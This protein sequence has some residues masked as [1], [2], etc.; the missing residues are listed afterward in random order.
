[1]FPLNCQSQMNLRKIRKF[2]ENKNRTKRYQKSSI[3]YMQELLNND[4]RRRKS[5]MKEPD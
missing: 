3:P 5:I 1:M 4:A 2:K